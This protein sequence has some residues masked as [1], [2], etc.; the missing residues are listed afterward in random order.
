MATPNTVHRIALTIAGLGVSLLAGSPAHADRNALW[1]IVNGSCVAPG[2]NGEAPKPK[3]GVEITCRLDHG[4][5]ILKDRE[6]VA[7]ML[8]IPTKR[9]TGIEDPSVLAAD[10]PHYFADAW[11]AR[12]AVEA[13]L[14]RDLPREAVAVTVN[15]EFARSQDQLHLHVDCLDV[16]VAAAL[17]D[18]QPSLDDAWRPMIVALNGRKYWARRLISAEL[19]DVSPFVALAEGLPA[20][21]TEMGLWTLAAVGATFNGD[22]G[23]VLLADHAELTAGGHA[24]DIQDHRCAIAPKS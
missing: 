18:Y 14:G 19:A 16:S 10:A 21:K 13:H 5:A 2:P 8:A 4:V 9:V 12:G 22:L 11:A 15:S 23:F 6:G 7:Q 1:N 24:E 17:K 20:A 3:P